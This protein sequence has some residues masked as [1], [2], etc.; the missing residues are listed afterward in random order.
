MSSVAGFGPLDEKET[1]N[2]ANVSL[3]SVLFNMDAVGLLFECS[4]NIISSKFP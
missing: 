2:G 3:T 4:K 1:I